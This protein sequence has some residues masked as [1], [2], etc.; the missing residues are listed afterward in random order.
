MMGYFSL[1][2]GTTPNNSCTYK[3]VYFGGGGVLQKILSWMCSPDFDILTFAI[4]VPNIVQFTIHQCTSFAENKQTNHH[5]L[6]IYP[7]YVNC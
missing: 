3:S 5:L 2:N 7:I 1:K 6:K 4:P